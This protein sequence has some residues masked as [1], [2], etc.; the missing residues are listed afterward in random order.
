MKKNVPLIF[1]VLVHDCK[2]HLLYNLKFVNHV[3]F[4]KVVKYMYFGQ[5]FAADLTTKDFMSE[6]SPLRYFI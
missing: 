5:D 4:F 1:T 3:S 2:I 6:E